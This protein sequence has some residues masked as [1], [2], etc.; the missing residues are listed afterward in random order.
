[1]KKMHADSLMNCL[2]EGQI[3]LLK[4]RLDYPTLRV[5]G[6]RVVLDGWDRCLMEGA[7]AWAPAEMGIPQAVQLAFERMVGFLVLGNGNVKY[8]N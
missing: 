3:A 2:T 1:M 5:Q 7:V 6:G 8:P 4:T